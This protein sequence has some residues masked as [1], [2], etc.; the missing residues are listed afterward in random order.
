M[1]KILF[2]GLCLLAFLPVM[3]VRANDGVYYTRGS[4]LVPLTETDISVRKEVLTIS[5]M[6]NGFARVDVYYEFWNPGKE[7]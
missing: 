6:D 3:P 4:Q 1:K 7:V 5:I 2:Y